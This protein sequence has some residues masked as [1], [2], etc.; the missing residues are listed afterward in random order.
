MR[1][2]TSIYHLSMKFPTPNR[3]GCVRGCQY[4]SRDFY[5][6]LVKGFRKNNRMDV[7]EVVEENEELRKERIL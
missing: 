5:N 6:K 1:V 3:I 7:N 2:V 4:D